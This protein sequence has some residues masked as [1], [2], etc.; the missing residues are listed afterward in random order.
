MKLLVQQDA[1]QMDIYMSSA[2][3]CV[4]YHCLFFCSVTASEH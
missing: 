4:Y 1:Y 2:T 3:V